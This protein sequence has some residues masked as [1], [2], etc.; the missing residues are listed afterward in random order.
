MQL[1]M[2]KFIMMKNIQYVEHLCDAVIWYE[3]VLQALM[4]ASCGMQNVVVIKDSSAV[5]HL[6]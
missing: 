4:S 6:T 2:Y 1:S 5:D 3:A